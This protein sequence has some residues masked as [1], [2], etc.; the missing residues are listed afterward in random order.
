[1]NSY[2]EVL[3]RLVALVAVGAGVGPVLVVADLHV[4]LHA[5]LRH[6]L[7]VAQFTQIA[8]ATLVVHHF[9]RPELANIEHNQFRMR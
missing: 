8:L 6:D 4:S 1:M 2:L 3:L 7:L 5:A 9:V